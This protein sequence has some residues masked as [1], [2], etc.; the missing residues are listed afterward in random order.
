MSRR[1]S[2]W[3]DFVSNFRSKEKAPFAWEFGFTKTCNWDGKA[4][5][6]S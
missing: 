2:L 5:P 6:K 1:R 3:P 4:S